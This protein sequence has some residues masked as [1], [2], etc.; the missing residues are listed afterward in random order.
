MSCLPG[1]DRA[2]ARVKAKEIESKIMSSVYLLDQKIEVQLRVSVGTATCPED[3]T[4]LYDL[5]AAADR[6]L[7]GLKARIRKRFVSRYRK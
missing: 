6:E 7:F 5:L 3:A 2:R 4:D 1:F